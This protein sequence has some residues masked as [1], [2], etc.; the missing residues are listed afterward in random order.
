MNEDMIY[1]AGYIIFTAWEK[2][3]ITGASFTM[4]S[5]SLKNPRHTISTA[6]PFLPPVNSLAI[7]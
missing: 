1:M 4:G 7:V 6:L 3:F 5:L 2:K